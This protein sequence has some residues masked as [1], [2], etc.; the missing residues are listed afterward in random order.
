[1]WRRYGRQHFPAPSR[2]DNDNMDERET[3]RRWVQAWK[4]AGPE[5]E[6]IRREEIGRLDTLSVLA[7]LEGAFHQALRQMPPRPSSG[8]VEMQDWF[9]RLRR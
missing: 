1:M 4:E 5:L 2:V 3:M 7:G 8:M 6:A 9:A